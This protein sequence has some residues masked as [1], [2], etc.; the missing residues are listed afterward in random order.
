MQAPDGHEAQFIWTPG[1]SWLD[2]FYLPQLGISPPSPKVR[3][4]GSPQA[5][6]MRLPT[7]PRPT[8]HHRVVYIPHVSNTIASSSSSSNT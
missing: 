2:D 5:P 3:R 4:T 1:L 7:G 6:R 8:E